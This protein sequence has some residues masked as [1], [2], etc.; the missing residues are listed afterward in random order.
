[1]PG[2]FCVSLLG[3]EAFV[4]RGPLLTPLSGCE[5]PQ[6]IYGHVHIVTSISSRYHGSVALGRAFCNVE[7]EIRQISLLGVKPRN[8]AT[9]PD[10]REPICREHGHS[11]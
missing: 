4:R 6:Q 11:A 9:R 5:L 7:I 8:E 2:I 1:M 10:R 3:S